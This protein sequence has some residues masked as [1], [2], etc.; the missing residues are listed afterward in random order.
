M[1]VNKI[2]VME[3]NE[4][5]SYIDTWTREE[6]IEHF[7]KIP[8]PVLRVKLKVFE[9]AQRKGLKKFNDRLKTDPEFAE[10]FRKFREEEKIKKGDAGKK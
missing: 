10:Q 2:E 5:F 7:M 3:N 9:Q 8:L 1:Q 6:I 4:D